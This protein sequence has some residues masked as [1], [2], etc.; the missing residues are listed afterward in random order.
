LRTTETQ[1]EL[2]NTY[3]EALINWN[4]TH[5]LIAKSQTSLL[6]DHIEDSLTIVEHVTKNVIDLGSGGGFPGIPVALVS[7]NKSIFLVES[8]TKKAAFL[9][10]AVNVLGLKNIKVFNERVEKIN[11]TAFPRPIDIIAR[12]FGTPKKT[13]E[14]SRKILD[15][16]GA[17][18]KIMTTGA[19]VEGEVLPGYEVTDKE[20]LLTKPHYKERFLVTIEKTN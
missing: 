18:L 1:K 20:K 5:N 16:P 6:N 4:K 11:P 10:H 7:K 3:K 9:L 8:N 19:G 13:V 2:L 12:A 17:K 15:T 14:A